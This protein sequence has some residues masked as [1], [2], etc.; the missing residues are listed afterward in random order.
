M[1]PTPGLVDVLYR[2]EIREGQRLSDVQRSRA[3]PGL[4]DMS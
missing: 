2:E 1:K 4:V 3:E